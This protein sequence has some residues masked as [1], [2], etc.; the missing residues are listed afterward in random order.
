MT[1]V[2]YSCRCYFWPLGL[3]IITTLCYYFTG[4]VSQW[5]DFRDLQGAGEQVTVYLA[6][7][8]ETKSALVS[9]GIPVPWQS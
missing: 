9:Y 8:E 5:Q 2:P 6:L 1:T 7:E 4:L 3:N